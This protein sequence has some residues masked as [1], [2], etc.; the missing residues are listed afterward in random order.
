MYNEA[1]LRMLNLPV[2]Q[3]WEELLD[4]RYRGLIA[5]CLPYA[6]GTMHEV[7]EIILQYYGEKEGWAYLR[8]LGAQVGRWTTGSVDTMHMVTRGE[9]PI[10]IAQPQMNAMVARRDGY[11]VGNLVPNVTILVPESAALLTNALMSGTLK[12]FWIGSTAK[13]AKIRAYGRLLPSKERH[14]P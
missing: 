9:Y 5:M 8:Y 1:V 7:C 10:G 14:L 11:P 6:S 3:T 4:P 13:R 12:S 2:P